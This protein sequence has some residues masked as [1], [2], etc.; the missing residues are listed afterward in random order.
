MRAIIFLAFCLLAGCGKAG[1]IE[2]G[3]PEYDRTIAALDYLNERAKRNDWKVEKSESPVTGG[4][5]VI[6]AKNA[7][8]SDAEGPLKG[9]DR[10]Y[11]PRLLI[12]CIEHSFDVVL[13]P[14]EYIGADATEVSWRAAGGQMRQRELRTSSSEDAVGWWGLHEAAPLID[15]ILSAETIA[16]RVKPYSR[17]PVDITFSR[18]NLREV[19]AEATSACGLSIE[20]M[21]A[22]AETYRSRP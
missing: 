13:D 12:R 9:E 10:E 22:N 4:K 1:T 11:G 16:F 8:W 17:L 5:R 7:M 20:S 14:D 18:K 6:L 21:L 19:I 3:T 15:D 2:P